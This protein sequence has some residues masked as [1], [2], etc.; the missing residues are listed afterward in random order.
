MMTFSDLVHFLCAGSHA[1]I[2]T[3]LFALLIEDEASSSYGSPVTN[4][5]LLA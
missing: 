5:S 4:G 3:R 1:L 2:F